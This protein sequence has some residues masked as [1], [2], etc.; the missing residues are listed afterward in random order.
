MAD[1]SRIVPTPAPADLP[2]KTILVNGTA[3]A[4]TYQV[5]SVKV[6]HIAHKVPEAEIILL[7]G[8][9]STET[10]DVSNGTD[11]MPG[12]DIE[13]KAG[14]HG[15]EETIFKGT[16]VKQGIKILQGQSSILSITAKH[17]IFKTTL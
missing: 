15:Q 17:K 5:M 7:D 13:I 12:V 1:D 4:S 14:Y 6:S 10:F 9:V 16:I 11:F 3:I 8:D 2:T